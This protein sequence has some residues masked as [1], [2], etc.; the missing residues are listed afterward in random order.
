MTSQEMS[1]EFDI[2]YNNIAS[3]MAPGLDEYEKSVFLTKAQEQLVTAIYD[4]T[5]EGSEKLRECIN[6]LVTTVEIS[7]NDAETSAVKTVSSDSKL[8][9]LPENAWYIV[10]ESITP[11]DTESC[12]DGKTVTV[13]PIKVDEY[14]RIRRNPFR[15]A[16]KDEALRL[17]SEGKIELISTYDSYTYKVRFIRRPIPIMIPYS[18]ADESLEISGVPYIKEGQ[19]CELLDAIH[20]AIIETAVSLAITTYKSTNNN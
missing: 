4:G 12:I 10:Y 2:L 3:N 19:D 14:H 7:S 8:F 1:L 9:T 18:D 16:R 6:P 15:R 17:N 11:S 20:R 5:F 13:K